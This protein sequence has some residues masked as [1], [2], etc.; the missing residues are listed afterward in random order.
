MNPDSKRHNEIISLI[1]KTCE[2]KKKLLLGYK[3]ILFGSRA[4]GF[5][6]SRADFDIGI[7]GK[8]P[9]S[10]ENYFILKD[11]FDNLPTLFHIDLVDFSRT[12]RNFKDEALN[13]YQL[14]YG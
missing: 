6:K 5:V 12:D 10:L 7:L 13:N 8:K 11:A 4:R 3:I 9:L 2:S 1:V 14:L